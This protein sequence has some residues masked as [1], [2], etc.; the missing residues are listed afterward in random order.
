MH[1]K[2][3]S[4][5]EIHAMEGTG[6]FSSKAGH[7]AVQRHRCGTHF[8]VHLSVDKQV[9]IF[10]PLVIII[11]F[12]SSMQVSTQLATFKECLATD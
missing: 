11:V 12:P 6:R 2:R 8:R 5:V 4:A 1:C 10:L 9:S 7:R 3:K